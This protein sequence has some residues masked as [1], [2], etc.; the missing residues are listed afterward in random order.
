[1]TDK[2]KLEITV[3]TLKQCVIPSGAYDMDRLR[4]AEN[5]I[6]NI[7][8]QAKKTLDEIGEDY[9]NVEVEQ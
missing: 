3:K 8:E 5:T 9:S 1:M 4:H 6:K 7:S 2:E